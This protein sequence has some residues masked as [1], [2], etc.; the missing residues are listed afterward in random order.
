[1]KLICAFVFAYA[2][3]WF[4]HDGAQ[5]VFDNEPAHW[6]V[7]FVREAISKVQTSWCI[8]A[9]IVVFVRVAISKVKTSWCI[10]AVY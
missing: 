2:K 4:S 9:V 10:N 1:M 5:M 8:N 7:V 6:I 3:C